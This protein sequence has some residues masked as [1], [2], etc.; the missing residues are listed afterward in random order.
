MEPKVRETIEITPELLEQVAVQ[1]EK[2]VI[3]HGVIQDG[4]NVIYNPRL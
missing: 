4:N 1:V 3:I 2:Q